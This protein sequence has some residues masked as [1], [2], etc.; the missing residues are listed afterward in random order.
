VHLYVGA[1]AT[2]HIA[3]DKHTLSVKGFRNLVAGEDDEL[4]A[5]Y[6]Q[7]HKMVDQEN[8]AVRMAILAGVEQL[9]QEGSS[10]H[11]D[12]KEGLVLAGRIEQNTK[13]I[14]TNTGRVD[15]YLES[16]TFFRF[17]FLHSNISYDS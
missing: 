10:T 6:A 2:E 13:T 11:A 1:L 5:A 7:F 16:K 9:K 14:L 8:G 17:K 3:I 15:Q 12:V 4:T